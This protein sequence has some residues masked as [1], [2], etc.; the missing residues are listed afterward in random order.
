MPRRP[1][2]Q[3][4][5]RKLLKYSQLFAA[6]G[7]GSVGAQIAGLK[8]GRRKATVECTNALPLAGVTAW[9]SMAAWWS[10]L[11]EAASG[12]TRHSVSTLGAAIAYYSLFSMGPLI[13][14]VVAVAGLVFGEEA[15]RGQVSL[16]LSALLGQQGAKGVEDMLAVAGQ[17]T[18]GVFAAL[19]STGAL[20]FAAIGVVVQLK[21]AL[22]TVWEVKVP[23]S[24]GVW[25]FFRIYAV[26]FAG[27]VS[28]GFLLLVSL[29]LTTL[30]SAVGTM[31]AGSLPELLLQIAGFGASFAM[32]SLLFGLMFKW[33]PDIEIGW[34]EVL[35]GSVLT[36][37]LFEIGKFLIGFY[38]GKQGLESTYGAAASLVVI[39]IWVYYSAQI[40]LFGA[41][42]TR[43][44]AQ[45][46]RA[47]TPKA[48]LLVGQEEVREHE[49][50]IP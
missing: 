29:L 2:S 27:V 32:T 19:V 49:P 47:R 37:M 14:I 6:F 10:I 4:P 17:P 3:T 28:L 24:S 44:Y 25:S 30:L 21:A 36:A 22:N 33:L 12:W 34:R 23:A 1:T 16:Q 38:I 13:L 8:T 35:P 5:L 31:F 42:F 7:V 18:E 50:D 41:E 39:L 45:L 26:S 15:V 43:A 48:P 46:W 9:L 40:V 11:R 20:I